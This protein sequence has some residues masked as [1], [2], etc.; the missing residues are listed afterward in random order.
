M[1]DTVTTFFQKARGRT[2]E[3]VGVKSVVLIQRLF[4]EFSTFLSILNCFSVIII[5]FSSNENCFSPV[6][7]LYFQLLDFSVTMQGNPIKC[8]MPGTSF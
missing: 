6:T 5:F 3:V 8:M 4:H 2:R 1:S 7:E